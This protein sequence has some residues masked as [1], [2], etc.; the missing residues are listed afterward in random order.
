MRRSMTLKESPHPFSHQRLANE[1]SK[2]NKNKKKQTTTKQKK[3]PW[4]YTNLTVTNTNWACSKTF[5]LRA[6]QNTSANSGARTGTRD[7][8]GRNTYT[9]WLKPQWKSNPTTAWAQSIP[10]FFAT[11]WIPLTKKLS[12]G[13]ASERTFLRKREPRTWQ[14]LRE[15]PIFELRKSDVQRWFVGQLQGIITFS[16]GC[17]C[18]QG[19][20]LQ[21]IRSI[22][23]RNRIVIWGAVLLKKKS[24]LIRMIA[25]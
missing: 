7:E 20:R 16:N 18:S 5:R 9:G 14:T 6:L 11:R 22:N 15:W 21:Q 10:S 4:T 8:V 2:A 25:R 24:D 17:T 1:R 13:T 12:K 19:E 23:S 3:T